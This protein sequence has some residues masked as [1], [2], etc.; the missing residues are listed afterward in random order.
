MSFGLPNEAGKTYTRISDAIEK[1]RK[2]R[3]DSVVFLAAVG[4][5]W[6]RGKDFPASDRNVIPI[7]AANSKGEF[8]PTNTTHTGKGSAKLCTYGTDIP[9]SISKEIQDHFPEADLS[10]G[11]SIATA[12]AAG[13]VAMTL[14]H[15]T[16]LPYLLELKG[17]ED[18]CAKLYTKSGMEKMLHA[19]SRSVGYQQHFIHPTW[20]W[21]KKT[22]DFDIFVSICRVVEELDEAKYD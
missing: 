2:E 17:S 15:L 18:V 10:A 21:G 6:E 1:V 4:N 22:K 16:V 20:F 14:S 7:Y 8:L 11:S 12:I 3:N 5:S 13:I 19:M 9:P